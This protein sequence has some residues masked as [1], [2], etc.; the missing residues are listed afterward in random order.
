MAYYYPQRA[1]RVERRDMSPP[2]VR[3]EG[4]KKTAIVNFKE[5][6][7]AMHRKPEHVMTFLEAELGT[8]GSLDSYHKLELNGRFVPK[9]LEGILKRYADKYVICY[10]CESENTSLVK[11]SGALFVRCR[12]C[13]W[14]IPSVIRL[15]ITHTLHRHS[16]PIVVPQTMEYNS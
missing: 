6:C 5:L 9:N 13:N 16:I 1:R 15:E 11:H 10:S 8:T 3:H 7:Q 4:I 12:R 2:R 14:D